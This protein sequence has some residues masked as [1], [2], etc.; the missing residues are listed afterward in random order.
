MA[1]AILSQLHLLNGSSLPADPVCS[2][3]VQVVGGVVSQSA[4]GHPVDRDAVR[5]AASRARRACR[6]P[7]S[8]K[9]LAST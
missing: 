9:E 7:R 4:R 8:G 1:V 2:T 5:G 6:N 3:H